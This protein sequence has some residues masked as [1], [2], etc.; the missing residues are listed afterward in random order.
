VLTS[1]STPSSTGGGGGQV[2]S[3]QFGVLVDSQ[4]PPPTPHHH[5]HFL[6]HS[7][8]NVKL[9]PGVNSYHGAG[10]LDDSVLMQMQMHCGQLQPLG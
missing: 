4:P 8:G 1:T 7:Y 2:I 5:H 6:P 10:F 3:E 9:E